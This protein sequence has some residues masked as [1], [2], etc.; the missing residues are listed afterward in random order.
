[1]IAP[2]PHASREMLAGLRLKQSA[3][4]AVVDG[5]L[6]L[7]EAA[8]RFRDAQCG[9]DGETLCRSVI[10]WVHLALSDRPERAEAVSSRL[11][12]ELQVYLDRAGRGRLLPV[13]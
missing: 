13:P 9:S 10:G 7:S 5:K 2:R 1:M 12:R 6:T 8:A 11:E 4:A 3:V